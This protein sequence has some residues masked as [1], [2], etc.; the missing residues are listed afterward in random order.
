LRNE[1]ILII[2]LGSAVHGFDVTEKQAIVFMNELTKVLTQV[3]EQEREKVL[4][5]WDKMLPYA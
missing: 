2:G 4:L 1:Q 5:N 3:D